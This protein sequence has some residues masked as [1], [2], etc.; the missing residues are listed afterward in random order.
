MPRRTGKT[1]TRT[2]VPSSSEPRQAALSVVPRD[3]TLCACSEPQ[4]RLRALPGHRL[5][6]SPAQVGIP[7]AVTRV[8]GDHVH[9]RLGR[10][11]PQLPGR[12][13]AAQRKVEAP[14]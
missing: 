7:S 5:D 13:E 12:R 8:A 10:A 3:G 6:P 11:V 2:P 1:P 9:V 14:R 4:S